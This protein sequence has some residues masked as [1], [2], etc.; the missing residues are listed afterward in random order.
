MRSE[1][2]TR[3]FLV[4]VGT[5]LTVFSIGAALRSAD[6]L[7]LCLP[8][9]F[10]FFFCMQG[11]PPL[12]TITRSPVPERGMAESR[13]PVS[14]SIFVQNPAPFMEVYECTRGR[15]QK[16]RYF[17]SPGQLQTHFSYDLTLRRGTTHIGPTRVRHY[18]FLF[19]RYWEDEL[20]ESS[21]VVIPQILPLKPLNLSPRRTKVFY[22]TIPSRKTGIGEEFFSLREYIPGDEYRKINW[23]AFGR[24]GT[25]ITNEFEALKI[26]DVV[27]ILD[28]RKETAL[29]N[30]KNLLDYALDATASLSVAVLKGGNRLGF[31][32]Y[33]DQFHY[34]YPGT[35][36]RH[37]FKILSIL[38]EIQSEGYLTLE[39]VRNFISAFYSKGSQLILISPL[40]D[41]SI[42]KAVQNLYVRGFDIFIVSPSPLSVEWIQCDHDIYHQ[43]ARKILEKKRSKLLSQLHEYAVLVNWDVRQPLGRALSEVRLFRQIR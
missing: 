18:N 27:C 17:L 7:T 37:L 11:E 4:V 34:L 2:Y 33:G 30:D 9:L 12:T 14:Y 23:K 13:L 6:I 28:A 15:E 32:A 16:L 19:T 39:Y 21:T 3:K 35:T 43:I 38:T 42:L 22:G 24:Y 25:L 8:L 36:R 10:Y 41:D 29:G 26:T 1:M 31:F 20:E 5:L 40:V